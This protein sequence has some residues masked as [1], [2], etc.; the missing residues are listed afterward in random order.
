MR[1]A[2]AKY[3]YRAVKRRIPNT[4]VVSS[5]IENAE[6]ML[7]RLDLSEWGMDEPVL[8][9]E[10][11]EYLL[12][13]PPPLSDTVPYV[14]LSCSTAS[15]FSAGSSVLDW[16]PGAETKATSQSRAFRPITA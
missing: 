8:A 13:P 6:A 10:I 3:P 11:E 5:G 9:L 12:A 14:C 4:G 1:K 2:T 16:I 15:A 7:L